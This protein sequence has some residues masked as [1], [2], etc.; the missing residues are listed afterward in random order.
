MS[1]T[2]SSVQSAWVVILSL[3]FLKAAHQGDDRL[4]LGRCE[5]G[6]HPA[7]VRRDRGLRLRK[8]AFAGVGQME[9]DAPSVIRRRPALDQPAA[10]ERVGDAEHGGPIDLEQAGEINLRK[11]WI[12]RDQ[13]EHRG[14]LLCQLQAL[15]MLSEILENGIVRDADME[16]DDFGEGAE[17]DVSTFCPRLD[18]VRPVGPSRGRLPDLLVA[19]A[20]HAVTASR[21]RASAPRADGREWPASAAPRRAEAMRSASWSSATKNAPRRR[22]RRTAAELF[23]RCGRPRPPSRCPCCACSPDRSGS[24]TCSARSGRPSGKG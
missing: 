12:L 8:K 6:L 23:R 4:D 16:A 2:C 17:A 11:P 9:A 20:T 7:L 22:S 14:L 13:P 15:E 18:V 1:K 5:A 21:A 24:S 10:A 3:L 19:L